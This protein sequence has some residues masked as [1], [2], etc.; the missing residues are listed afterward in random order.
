MSDNLIPLGSNPE[1]DKEIRRMGQKAQAEKKRQRR[2]LK[3]DLLALLSTEK[4]GKTLQEA[5]VVAIL[6]QALNGNIKAYTAIEASIGEKPVE[7]VENTITSENKEA[8]DS[9]L[10]E[11]KNGKSKN[12]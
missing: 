11:V 3:E 5:M 9:Y 7:R 4:D 12:T 10:K 8:L 1:R 2:T 6:K